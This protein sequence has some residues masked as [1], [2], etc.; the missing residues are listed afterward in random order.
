M[1]EGRFELSPAA[2]NDLHEIRH[3]IE[4]VQREPEAA[5][6]VLLRLQDALEQL[7]RMP[8]MGHRRQDLTEKD[9]RFW[10]VYSYLII[11]QPDTNPLRIVRVLSAYRDVAEILS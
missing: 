6:R 7:A 8:G 9:L 4:I 10:S 2:K 3:F 5:R 1:S 11:Y